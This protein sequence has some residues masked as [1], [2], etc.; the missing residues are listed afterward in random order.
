MAYSLILGCQKLIKI[1]DF[2]DVR[3]KTHINR[4]GK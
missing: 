3:Q 2:E 4:R 1:S